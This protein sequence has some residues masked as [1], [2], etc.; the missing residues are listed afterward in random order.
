VAFVSGAAFYQKNTVSH[1]M[2]LDFT[3]SNEAEILQGLERLAE[4]ITG[5]GQDYMMRNYHE[6]GS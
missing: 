6:P 2:R 5:V 3:N 4:L 1:S